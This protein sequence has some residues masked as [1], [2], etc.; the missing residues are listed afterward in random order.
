M[1]GRELPASFGKGSSCA[2]L[3]NFRQFFLSCPDPEI[4][5]TLCRELRSIQFKGT[6]FG[7]VTSLS[8]AWVSSD[9]T[10]PTESSRKIEDVFASDRC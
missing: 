10:L 7:L 4:C 2:K 1:E 9:N 8:R 5:Y 3:R 6:L